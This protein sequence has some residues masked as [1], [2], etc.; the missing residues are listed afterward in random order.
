MSEFE[1]RVAINMAEAAQ[2]EGRM[3]GA[4]NRDSVSNLDLEHAFGELSGGLLGGLDLYHHSANLFECFT[5]SQNRYLMYLLSRMLREYNR[6]HHRQRVSYQFESL[7]Q[8]F[9]NRAS[10]TYRVEEDP[11]VV[12]FDKKR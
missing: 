4:L 1:L 8:T 9:R 2:L 6:R 10:G 3:Y 5:E 12:A 11:K 7:D